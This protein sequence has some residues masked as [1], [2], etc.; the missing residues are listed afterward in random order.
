ME[1]KARIREVCGTVNYLR[2]GRSSLVSRGLFTMADVAA[3]GLRRND[4]KAHDLQP[5][6]LLGGRRAE[7]QGMC[8]GAASPSAPCGARFVEARQSDRFVTG[9]LT[10][11][12]QTDPCYD[13]NAIHEFFGPIASVVPGPA[14]SN[15]GYCEEARSDP[16]VLDPGGGCRF[17]RKV[18]GESF[19]GLGTNCTVR[20]ARWS[21][22][23]K[24]RPAPPSGGPA[25]S[26]KMVTAAPRLRN[27]ILSPSRVLRA[28]RCP[29][30]AAY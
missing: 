29:N 21:G 24:R 13:R 11:E 6:S 25:S 26:E 19:S 8:R 4:P 3:A 17:A 16:F 10:S 27:D 20:F 30:Q 15:A 14:I 9:T 5:C 7:A 18:A 12:G 28:G 1:G 23:K 22:V 2:P